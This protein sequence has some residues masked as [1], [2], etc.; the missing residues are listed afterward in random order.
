M[1]GI[2]VY[3]DEQTVPAKDHAGDMIWQ[4]L[5]GHFPASL[6]PAVRAMFDREG[7]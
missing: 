1:N 7:P 4:R 6:A 2:L 5:F 3:W